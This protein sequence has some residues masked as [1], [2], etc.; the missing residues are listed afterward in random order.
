[1]VTH[2]QNYRRLIRQNYDP[3]EYETLDHIFQLYIR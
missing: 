1:M 2:V 3:I